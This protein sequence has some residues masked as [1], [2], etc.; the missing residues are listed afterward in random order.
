MHIHSPFELV[1]FASGRMAMSGAM[2]GRAFCFSLGERAARMIWR[3]L[4]KHRRATG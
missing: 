1:G 4:F 3:V 2:S